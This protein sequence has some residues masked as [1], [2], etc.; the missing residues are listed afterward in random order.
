MIQ[1]LLWLLVSLAF[2]ISA[3]VF[4]SGM[5]TSAFLGPALHYMFAI[6]SCLVQLMQAP[7]RCAAACYNLLRPRPPPLP[8]PSLSTVSPKSRGTRS[9]CY[10]NNTFLWIGILLHHVQSVSAVD[11]SS[12]AL[13]VSFDWLFLVV[14]FLRLCWLYPLFGYLCQECSAF[15]YTTPSTKPDTTETPSTSTMLSSS[16]PI[17]VHPESLS[18]L[19]VPNTNTPS[20]VNFCITPSIALCF[21]PC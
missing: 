6:M 16:A 10:Y 13:E 1:V 15:L 5:T 14:M 19:I 9:V 21:C 20:S 8:D 12:I 7:L 4:G 17:G 2:L 18:L 11:I 3:S